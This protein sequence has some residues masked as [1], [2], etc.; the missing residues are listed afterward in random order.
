MEGVHTA[1]SV[2]M[3]FLCWKITG[4][5]L[6]MRHHGIGVK[7]NMG[8]H[9]I[10]RHGLGLGAAMAPKFKGAFPPVEFHFLFFSMAVTV[11]GGQDQQQRRP[12]HAHAMN[13]LIRSR[14]K[15]LWSWCVANYP[16]ITITSTDCLPPLVLPEPFPVPPVPPV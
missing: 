5:D 7:N 12:F 9:G 14:M 1:I 15:L 13:N 8:H 4:N 3:Y 2:I 6:N 11:V 10:T 16:A